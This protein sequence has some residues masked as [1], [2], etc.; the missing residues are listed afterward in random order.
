MEQRSPTLMRRLSMGSGPNSMHR[1]TLRC[2]ARGQL[3]APCYEEDYEQAMRPHSGPAL[4]S[5][6][7]SSLQ[8]VGGDSH[9]T[10]VPGTKV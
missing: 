8:L 2:G 3:D 1:H 7:T 4:M 9:R 5:L 6:L 10:C